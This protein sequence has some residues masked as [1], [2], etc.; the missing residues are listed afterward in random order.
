VIVCE[1]NDILMGAL[2]D[3]VDFVFRATEAEIQ[4]RID[5]ESNMK[6]DYVAGLYNHKAGLVMMLDLKKVLSIQDIQS[7]KNQNQ[8]HG[9]KASA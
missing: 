8:G 9:Q 3:S 1:F 4:T 7:I 2:V 6:V 5:V